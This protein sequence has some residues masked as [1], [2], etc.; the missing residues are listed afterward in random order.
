MFTMAQSIW[1]EGVMEY[2]RTQGSITPTPT[3]IAPRPQ[4]LPIGSRT[5][6]GSNATPGTNGT[7]LQ[8]SSAVPASAPAKGGNVWTSGGGRALTQSVAALRGVS[9]AAS[10]HPAPSVAAS[11]VASQLNQLTINPAAAYFTPSEAPGA[12]VMGNGGKVRQAPTTQASTSSVVQ[13][14]GSP[15]CKLSNYRRQ[16]F[17][18]GDIIS[19]PFHT[20][21][22][23]PNV[24]P[25][26]DCLAKTKEGYVYSKRRMLIVLWVYSQDVFC[27]PLY[28]F[29]GKGIQGKPET[30][31]KEYVSV[32]NEADK[33]FVNQGLYP[34]IP[35]VST[36]KPLTPM[37]AAHL[38][39]GIKV[40]CSEHIVLC[41]RATMAGYERLLE[42]WNDLCLKAQSESWRP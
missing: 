15:Y 33:R 14:N 38:T 31:R 37:T 20:P 4:Q 36:K 2:P 1:I 16:D 25:N 27:V 21:N 11:Q 10:R 23:N 6:V 42:L 3:P 39:G 19:I 5:V 40:N 35:V 17:R 7:Q 22:M 12:T 18:H 9:V 13:Q 30:L 28:S 24:D 8:S 34:P 32:R 41:G 29:E 26:D